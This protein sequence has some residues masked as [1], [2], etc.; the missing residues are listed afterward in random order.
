MIVIRGLAAMASIGMPR[1]RHHRDAIA[2][3]T[4]PIAVQW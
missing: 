3:T 2:G 1:D 4:T